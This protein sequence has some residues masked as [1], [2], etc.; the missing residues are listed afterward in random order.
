[1]DKTVAG[2]GWFGYDPG[3]VL[4]LEDNLPA[5]GRY[6]HN[7]NGQDDGVQ[8]SQCNQVGEQRGILRIF[9]AT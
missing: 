7:F 3:C 1:M 2:R 4:K 8:E 5:T 6:P 9:V